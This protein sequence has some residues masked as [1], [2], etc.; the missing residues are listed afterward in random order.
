[1]ALEPTMKDLQSQNAQLQQLILNLFKGQEELKAFLTKDMKRKNLEDI[2]DDQLEQLQAEV[3]KMKIQMNGQTT[4][5]QNLARGQEELRVLVS[6]L[7]DNRVRD[8]IISRPPVK[9][10]RVFQPSK[11]KEI[12]PI[13][14]EVWDTLGQPSSKFDFMVKYTA[15]ES[16]KISIEDIQ[17]TG[18][19][20]I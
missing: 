4:L 3:T 18:W 11:K 7:Q 6:K 15:P 12:P 17:P 16:S 8:P 10:K 1:M 14:A 5:I 19:E 20:I 9:S 13:P 2:K